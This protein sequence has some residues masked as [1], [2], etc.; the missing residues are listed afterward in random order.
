[1]LWQHRTIASAGFGGPFPPQIRC[2]N[3]GNTAQLRL[4]ILTNSFRQ[5]YAQK[6]CNT[7]SIPAVFHLFLTQILSSD[8]LVELCGIAL[9][10]HKVFLRFHNKFVMKNSS[11]NLLAELCGIAL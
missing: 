3:Y 11:P 9:E 8:S 4:R 10:I 5:K 7:Q 1:M 6:P 2:E